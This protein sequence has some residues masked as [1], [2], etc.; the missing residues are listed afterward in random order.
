[1][2]QLSYRRHRFP[3]SITR[4]PARQ[5]SVRHRTK[6]L[7]GAQIERMMRRSIQFRVLCPHRPVPY[8]GGFSIRWRPAA[9]FTAPP[10]TTPQEKSLNAA[11]FCF[12]QPIPPELPRRPR[13]GQ[14]RLRS[15]PRLQPLFR[16]SLI[17]VFSCDLARLAQITGSKRQPG[18]NQRAAGPYPELLDRLVWLRRFSVSVNAAIG[19]P[20]FGNVAHPT[21]SRCGSSPTPLAHCRSVE[22]R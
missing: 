9:S 13:D 21:A 11:R 19:S 2:D 5:H 12:A 1:M 6:L 10:P 18:V 14:A 20:A 15:Q 17:S 3:P 8:R 4:T 16:G 22:T 7:T